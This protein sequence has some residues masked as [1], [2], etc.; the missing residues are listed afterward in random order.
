MTEPRILRV[1]EEPPALDDG[2]TRRNGAGPRRDKPKGKTG[3]A[4]RFAVLNAFAD[5]TLANLARAEIAVWLLLWRDT[6]PNGLARTSQA[7]LARRAGV[8]PRTVRRALAAMQNAGLVTVVHK[9]GL[10]LRVSAYR[11][12][13]LAIIGNRGPPH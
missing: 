2:E 4:G 8:N 13:A 10:P 3:S 1:G 5:A 12:H 9:G 6:K 7:D 11:V